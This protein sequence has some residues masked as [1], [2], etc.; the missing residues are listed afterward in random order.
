MDK[1]RCKTLLENDLLHEIN[2][3]NVRNMTHAQIVQV[4]KDCPVGTETAII[5][6]RGGKNSNF[7]YF[8]FIFHG[9]GIYSLDLLSFTK[10]AKYYH[11]DKCLI[12]EIFW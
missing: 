2:N 7:C 1:P 9:K 12:F 4:L 5:V 3:I 10:I 11:E 6:Q 8:E